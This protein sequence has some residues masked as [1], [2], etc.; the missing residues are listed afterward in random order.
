MPVLASQHRASVG[1][2]QN[3]LPGNFRR[4]STQAQGINSGSAAILDEIRHFGNRINRAVNSY[5]ELNRVSY[6]NTTLRQGIAVPLLMLLSQIRLADSPLSETNDTPT[7]VSERDNRLSS[8][9]PRNAAHLDNS[10]NGFSAILSPVVN[11][12]YEAGE[13][14]ARHDPL[15]F[16]AAT[17]SSL[18]A[19]TASGNKVMHEIQNNSINKAL[20][21]ELTRSDILNATGGT[22]LEPVILFFPVPPG[23][24]RNKRANAREMAQIQ[25]VEYQKYLSEN[26]HIRIKTNQGTV[27]GDNLLVSGEMVR[28]PIRAA[29]EKIYENGMAGHEMPDW[30]VAFTEGA[31]IGYDIVLGIMT[32]GAYP[33]IKYASSKALSASGHAVNV[34]TTCLKREFSP[35]ELA[36]LLF[37]TEVGLTNRHA[38]NSFRVK[39]RPGELKNVRS[40]VPDG[41]FVHENTATRLNTVNYMTVSHQGIEYRI[42]EKS[43][44]EYWTFHP[45]AVKPELVE[46][47]VYFDAVN[48]KIHFNSEMPKGQGLDYN[49]IE[50]KKFISLYGENHEVTWNWDNNRPEVVLHKKNSETLNVPVYMD[51]LSKTWHLSA[52]NGHPAFSKKQ[53][54]FINKV[55][56]NE[57]SDF[58]YVPRKNNNH[59]YYGSGNIYVQEKMGDASHYPL[60]RHIEMNGELVPVKE[61]V[62]PGHGVHYEVFDLNNPSGKSYP[63]EW[64]G[65]RWLFE[66]KT[67]VH[68]SKDLKKLISSN[69]FVKNVDTTRLSAPDSYGLRWDEK[70]N[71]YLKVNNRFIKVSKLNSNRFSLPASG[72]QHRTILRF[73]NKFRI[74]TARERLKNILE[75]GLGGRKRKTAVS[76]LKEQDGFTENGARELL[77][78]YDFPENSFY[79]Y[80]FALDVEQTGAIPLWAER[81]KKRPRMDGRQEEIIE[82]I[83]VSKPDF[84]QLKVKY[85]LGEQVGEGG[86]GEVFVD[87]DDKRYLIKKYFSDQFTYPLETAKQEAGMFNRFYGEDS[88]MVLVGEGGSVY[89]RMYKVPGETLGSLSP[90]SLP[91]DAEQRFVD[92]IEKLNNL[93]IMHDD[94]HSENILW[95]ADSQLF[96]PI[97]IRNTR[98]KYFNSDAKTKV[99]MN[100]TGEDDW[101]S[102]LDEIGDKKIN[103]HMDT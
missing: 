38:F 81:F 42:K 98:E 56:T 32:A 96:Y 87:V 53:T 8:S 13:F 72:K 5:E 101:Y 4:N 15:K 79:D 21:H 36:N 63:V 43:P 85:N 89:V 39:P 7:F 16:P 14:I 41:I 61:I 75:T 94:I 30:M 55:K 31:N 47:R 90:G 28:N 9:A 92:M 26:C 11:A 68:V 65:N 18:P 77:A 74:E 100:K 51:P 33:I 52:H 12:L 57:E 29:A 45:Y 20:F 48:N 60:G 3:N 102:I 62:T 73:N 23:A 50:G 88:A 34:D 103:P 64:D 35:E 24:A 10:D 76:V 46:K 66:R 44:G 49:I 80:T 19:N 54:D 27:V 69:M 99:E 95:D 6:Q 40:F 58:H 22:A 70:G 2:Y 1:T 17:A 86:F 67:S 25:D 59:N 97:D 82:K 83:I 84:P 37:D 78:K 91:D 71:R 93:G